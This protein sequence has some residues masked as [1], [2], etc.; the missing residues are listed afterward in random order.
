MQ[1]IAKIVTEAFLMVLA[2]LATPDTLKEFRIDAIDEN[3]YMDTM[4]V[5]RTDDGFILYD[6]M[7]N[8]LKEFMTIKV[9]KDNP[10]EYNVVAFGDKKETVNFDKSIKQFSLEKLRKE[11]QL[12]LE[13][14]DGTKIKINRSGSMVYLTQ[15]QQKR[16]YAVQ[17]FE[18][19]KK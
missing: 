1:A 16:T 3:G 13:I 2:A 7:N 12:T 5:H 14:I 18:Q 11:N 6:E 8:E 19:T 10:Q 9:S 15:S 4:I 17:C